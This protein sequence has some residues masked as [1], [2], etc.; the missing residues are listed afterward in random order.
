MDIKSSHL[1]KLKLKPM[2][3]IIQ[4]P[5]LFSAFAI[6]FLL[7][8]CNNKKQTD[9]DSKSDSIEYKVHFTF[10]RPEPP[11]QDYDTVLNYKFANQEQFNAW[12]KN[13]T[14]HKSAERVK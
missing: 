13:D 9:N 3:E 6:L 5:L 11:Y 1:Y 12:A 2:P 7:C 8:Q 14:I 4:A 10:T